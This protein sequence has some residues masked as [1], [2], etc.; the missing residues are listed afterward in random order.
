MSSRLDRITNWAQ[1][2]RQSGYRV[3]TLAED[4]GVTERQL[5]RYFLEK[6]QCSP[7]EWM[8]DRKFEWVCA[9]LASGELAKNLFQ[10]AGFSHPSHFSRA[11]RQHRGFPSGSTSAEV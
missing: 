4:C 3:S 10:Q 5:R 6:F 7:H 9:A 2:A 11:L 8:S 1:R